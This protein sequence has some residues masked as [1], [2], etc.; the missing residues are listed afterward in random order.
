MDTILG[1]P[2]AIETLRQSLRSGR[3][4]HAWIFAGSQGV[5]KFTAAVAFAKILLEVEG[6]PTGRAARLIEEGTHPDLHIIRRDLAPFSSN[7]ELRRKKLSNIPVD[8]LREHMVG[9]H[10]GGRYFEP[11]IFHSP[12]LARAKVFIIDEA[13]LLDREEGQNSLLKTLEEPPPRTYIILV[14]TQPDRLLPTIRSRAQRV[15]FLPLDDVAM[16]IWWQRSGLG[17]DLPAE[18]REWIDRFAQ[19]SPGMAAMAIEDRLFEWRGVIEPIIREAERGHFVPGAGDAIAKLVDEFAKGEQSDDENAS[20]ELGNREGAK[21]VF[22]MLG[23]H[24][25]RRLHDVVARGAD[26]HRALRRID[27]IR[28]AERALASSVNMRFVFEDL[29]AQWVEQGSPASAR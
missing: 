18:E 9:G 22:L 26:P 8:L 14:T 2:R 11:R 15:S 17:K 5:G 6:D 3:L 20:K 19:G 21:R 24:A 16:Q 10:S 25:G 27:Q 29:I 12:R 23:A 1:Q 7:A 13:E 4:H 28:E